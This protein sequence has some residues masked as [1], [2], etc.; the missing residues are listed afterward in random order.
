[1]DSGEEVDWIGIAAAVELEEA[2]AEAATAKEATSVARAVASAPRST[3]RK[4]P[5]DSDDWPGIPLAFNLPDVDP[6][7]G[8]RKQIE[9]YATPEIRDEMRRAYL[10]KGVGHLYGHDFSR[11]R[12]G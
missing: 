10:S 12:F 5:H 3:N 4:R 2:G 6:D 7:P 8:T 1:M 11:T 9:E